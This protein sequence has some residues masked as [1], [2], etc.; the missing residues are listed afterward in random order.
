MNL[1][2]NPGFETGTLAPWI[3]GIGGQARVVGASDATWVAPYEG[4][5]MLRLDA[6]TVT[7]TVTIPTGATSL[8][9]KYASNSYNTTRNTRLTAAFDTGDP[10]TDTI[11]GIDDQWHT[12]ERTIPVPTGATTLTFSVYASGTIRYDAFTLTAT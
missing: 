1:L 11:P 7:Q 10:W 12:V 2:D 9:L 3:A 6:A 8:R 4:A 5:W